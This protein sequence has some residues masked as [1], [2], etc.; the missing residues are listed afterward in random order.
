MKLWIG[1]L[2]IILASSFC[3]ADSDSTGILRGS[4]EKLSILLTNSTGSFDNS[5][6]CSISILDSGSTILV[7]YIEMVNDDRGAYSYSWAVPDDI[8]TYWMAVNC[9]TS[10][11]E[12]YTDGG[13]MFVVDKLLEKKV[14]V[15]VA[16]Y[17]DVY[18]E[19]YGVAST[20]STPIFSFGWIEISL[21][22]SVLIIIMLILYFGYKKR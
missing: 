17:E 19:Q 22:A 6:N 7:D 13:S 1:L 10:A 2:V 18:R 12:N 14:A 15:G 9:S 5:S 11:K 3:F 20:I 16:R 4:T 21:G 8:G